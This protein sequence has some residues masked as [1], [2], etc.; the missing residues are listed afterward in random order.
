MLKPFLVAG[1]VLAASPA[2]AQP[3]PPQCSA[4]EATTAAEEVRADGLVAQ[5]IHPTTPGRHPALLILGGSEGWR[6]T[7]CFFRDALAPRMARR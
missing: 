6:A 3:A 2:V 1:L 4:T 5:Y 7:L